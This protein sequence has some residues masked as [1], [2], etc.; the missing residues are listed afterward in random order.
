ME[1]ML[2]SIMEI[3]FEAKGSH[4]RAMEGPEARPQE[5]KGGPYQELVSQAAYSEW[6]SSS[7]SAGPFLPGSYFDSL[8]HKLAIGRS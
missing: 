2:L 1:S 6:G 3:F 7:L 4:F 8:A 5:V